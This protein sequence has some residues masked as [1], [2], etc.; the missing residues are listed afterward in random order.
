MPDVQDRG[1]FNMSEQTLWVNGRVFCRVCQLVRWVIKHPE[2]IVVCD[3]CGGSTVPASGD[4][5]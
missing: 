5:V 3:R 1:V 2:A 4:E